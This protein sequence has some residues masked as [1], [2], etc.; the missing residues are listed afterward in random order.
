VPKFF[1]KYVKRFFNFLKEKLG[2]YIQSIIL[3]GSVARDTWD[4]ESDIDLLLILKDNYFENHN[5]ETIS[6]LVIEFYNEIREEKTFKKYRFHSFQVLCLS[7]SEIKK[8]RTLFYDIAVDGIILCDKNNIGLK[9]IEE[10][11]K[12]IKNK[13]IKRIFI[14][15]NDFYWK[16]KEVK[17]GEIIEL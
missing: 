4:S 10:Y 8:F 16:R 6:S 11:R 9:L 1:R 12:R 15:E 7:R 17:F 3:Y 2:K 14:D 5:K 13:G